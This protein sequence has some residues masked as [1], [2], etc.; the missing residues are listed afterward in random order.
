MSQYV[1][2]LLVCFLKNLRECITQTDS[3][4]LPHNGKLSA[5]YFE[6]SRCHTSFA[7][8]HIASRLTDVL[9]CNRHR[10][11]RRMS[12]GVSTHPNDNRRQFGHAP[13][14]STGVSNR[15]KAAR[16]RL[17]CDANTF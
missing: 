2:K 5:V 10:L 6:S 8:K 15:T 14:K 9:Y 7:R 13:D 12:R 1:L 4:T 16:S 11:S 3:S 17:Y